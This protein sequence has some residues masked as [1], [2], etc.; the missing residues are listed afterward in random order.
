M[1][2]QE[3]LLTTPAN[4]TGSD[5]EFAACRRDGPHAFPRD[6]ERTRP[7]NTHDYPVQPVP[8]TA[9]HLTDVFWAPRIE[10]NRNVTIPAAFQKCEETGRVNIFVRAAQALRGEEHDKKAPGYP[11]DD[12]D[13]Y[14]VIEGA[15]YVA[16]RPSGSEARRLRRRHD[17]Q[18]RRRAGA[19]RLSLHDA[20]DRSAEPAPLVR[21]GALGQRA[22]RQPRALQPRPPVRGGGGA[23][24]GDRQ[25]DPAQRRHQGRR[26]AGEHVRPRQATIWPGHQITEMGAGE[27]VSR[28][29]QGGYLSLAKF[30]LDER[31]PDTAAGRRDGQPARPRLQPG[32]AAR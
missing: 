18:D 17:R 8:F 23:L 28:D 16:Q 12:T 14:K 13:V 15:S 1:A 20:H 5:H 4:P 27:A 24:P 25:E 2:C 10:T 26:P 3:R 30:L 21:Q 6:A 7:E 19:R 29:R 9:V 11:F 22:Q 32:A 31:G